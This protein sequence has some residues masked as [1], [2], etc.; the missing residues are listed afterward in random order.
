MPLFEAGLKVEPSRP[1][2]AAVSS[3]IGFCETTSRMRSTAAS[4]RSSAG[5]GR[6]L[7]DAD[8]EALVLVRDEA[9]R[10]RVQPPDR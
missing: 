1:A 10:S 5:A 7:D 6:Q 2:K 8:Q 9:G 3:T 4:V